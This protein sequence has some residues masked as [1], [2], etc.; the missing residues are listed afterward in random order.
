MELFYD[1]HTMDHLAILFGILE[2]FRYKNIYIFGDKILNL[3]YYYYYY[4]SP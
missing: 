2:P 3:A 1:G 4:Y